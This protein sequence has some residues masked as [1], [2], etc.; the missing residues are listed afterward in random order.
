MFLNFVRKD[1]LLRGERTIRWKYGGG[2]AR[3]SGRGLGVYL[4]QDSFC[5]LAVARKDRCSQAIRRVVHHGHG[6][7]IGAHLHK[8]GKEDSTPHV[9]DLIKLTRREKNEE[10]VFQILL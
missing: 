3:R 8:S 5:A 2:K 7:F 1:E 10:A 4:L 6:F 9:I